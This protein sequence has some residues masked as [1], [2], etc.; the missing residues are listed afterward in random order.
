MT[1]YVHDTQFFTTRTTVLAAII[2]LH[3]FI[4]WALATGLARRAIEVI[5]PPI[6]TDI[7]QE[8][9]NK[10]EPPPPPPPEMQKQVVEVPPPDINIAMPEVGPSSNAI[11]ASAVPH[12]TAPAPP[13]R[14]VART[15]MVI[16]AK[17]FPNSEDFYPQASKRLGEQGSPVVKICLGPDGKLAAGSPSIATSSGSPRLDEGAISLV[18]A[19]ARYIKPATEDGKPVAACQDLRIKFELH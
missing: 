14:A 19:G 2:A 7:V 15:A 12:P 11:T 13:P 1:A 5:A 8:E 18:K 16:D 6:Q 9:K 4:F 10:V 3:V 17:H